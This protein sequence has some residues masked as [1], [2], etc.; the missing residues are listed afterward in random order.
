ML[1]FLIVTCISTL[2]IYSREA[3][4]CRGCRSLGCLPRLPGADSLAGSN[5]TATHRWIHLYIAGLIMLGS[6]RIRSNLP[7][8][9]GPRTLEGNFISSVTNVPLDSRMGAVLCEDDVKLTSCGVTMTTSYTDACRIHPKTRT[10]N[11][12]SSSLCYEHH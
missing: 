8:R 4:E 10:Y 9:D 3:A 1:C 12:T 5:R 7:E 11:H 2:L 6:L